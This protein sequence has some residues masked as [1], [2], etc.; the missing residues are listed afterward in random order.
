M[1]T[2]EKLVLLVEAACLEYDF[3]IGIWKHG[4]QDAKTIID[5]YFSLPP[6]MQ[7]WYS[8]L[9]FG[10]MLSIASSNPEPSRLEKRAMRVAAKAKEKKVEC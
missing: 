2:E 4:Y 6:K 7:Q 5:Y 10:V 1:N 8:E 9:D 3:Q